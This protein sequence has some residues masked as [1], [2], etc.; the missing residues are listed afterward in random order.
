MDALL[1]KIQKT[2]CMR[3]L[4]RGGPWCAIP[5]WPNEGAQTTSNY[6]KFSRKI[7]GSLPGTSG[8]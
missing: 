8:T 7:F 4:I 3:L 6:M 1:R 2:L 5:S